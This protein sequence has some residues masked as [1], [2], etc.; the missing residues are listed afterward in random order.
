MK[1]LELVES[2]H[3]GGE[4]SILGTTLVNILFNTCSR[5]HLIHL[6]TSCGLNLQP[7]G[8]FDPVVAMLTLERG[9]A[10]ALNMCS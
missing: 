1:S 4:S 2:T 7:C 6:G 3:Q 10:K 9:R 5:D 8:S